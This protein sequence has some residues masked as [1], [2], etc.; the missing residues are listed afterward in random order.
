MTFNL[1]TNLEEIKLNHLAKYLNLLITKTQ[2]RRVGQTRPGPRPGSGRACDL[3]SIW[4]IFQSIIPIQL[5]L[6]TDKQT[7]RKQL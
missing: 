3:Y 1:H 7:N 2:K 6:A 5:T 4:D